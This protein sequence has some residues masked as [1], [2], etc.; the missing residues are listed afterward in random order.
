M[1]Y[2]A[3]LLSHS[4]ELVGLKFW[5]KKIYIYHKTYI[6]CRYGTIANNTANNEVAQWNSE[7]KSFNVSIL[8]CQNSKPFSKWQVI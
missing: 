7:Q 3:T 8:N 5:G 6:V 2:I 1:V 4:L